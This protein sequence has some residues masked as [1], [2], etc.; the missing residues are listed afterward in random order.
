MS[1]S[2]HFL[3]IKETTCLCSR[4]SGCPDSVIYFGWSLCCLFGSHHLVK[5]LCK[6]FWRFAPTS[7]TCGWPIYERYDSPEIGF[8]FTFSYDVGNKL[9]AIWNQTSCPFFCPLSFMNFRKAQQWVIFLINLWDNYKKWL[10]SY[11]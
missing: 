8:L 9:E 3:H 7:A 11:T 5:C 6:T 4:D 10:V 1:V 2:T